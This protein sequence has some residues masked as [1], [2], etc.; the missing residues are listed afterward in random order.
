MQNAV[1]IC[2]SVSILSSEIGFFFIWIEF[3]QFRHIIKS[4]RENR[5]NARFTVQF[6]GEYLKCANIGLPH[7]LNILILQI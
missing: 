6:G 2:I 1:E 7:Y 5:V 4:S 3:I